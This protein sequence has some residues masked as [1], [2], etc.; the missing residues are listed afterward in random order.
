M[1][2]PQ[3]SLLCLLIFTLALI[4]QG[5]FGVGI[6]ASLSTRE[7]SEGDT[8][9]LTITIT[10]NATSKPTIPQINGLTFDFAG[11]S[12]QFEMVNLQ[13]S[14]TYTYIYDVTG[15]KAGHYTINHI[16]IQADGKTLQAPPL[17]LTVLAAASNPAPDATNAGN[18]DESSGT[19]PSESLD[20]KEKKQTA[21][22]RLI[23]SKKVAYVGEL[24]P[25]QIRVYFHRVNQVRLT[26]L[27]TLDGTA[28]TLSKMDS[29]PAQQTMTIDGEPYTVLTWT[30]AISA[31]KDGTYNLGSN[32]QVT[33]LQQTRGMA[34]S[35]FFGDD[36]FDRF[37]GR[38][39]PK[40]LNLTSK[41]TTM[42][43]L[44]LPDENR[45]KSFTGPV[46]NFTFQVWPVRS[47]NI[48]EG[49]PINLKLVVSGAGNFDDVQSPQMTDDTGWTTY[50]PSEKFYPDNTP[51]T[52]GKKEFQ[53]AMIPQNSSIT[54]IPPFEF[55]YFDPTAARY[56]IKRTPPIPIKIIPAQHTATS[57]DT[58]SSDDQQ[59]NSS[60]P[61]NDFAPNRIE[62]ENF[63]K[64]LVPLWENPWFEA[65]WL[66]PLALLLTGGA[67][68]LRSCQIGSIHSRLRKKQANQAL[69]AT[70][71][72]MD[73]A[74]LQ[75]DS[76]KFLTSCRQVCQQHLAMQWGLPPHA[77]TSADV[78]EKMGETGTGF[79]RIF[80]LID[81]FDYSG[82]PITE[83]QMQE[84][85]ELVR[86][87]LQGVEVP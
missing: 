16:E 46:G 86:Q 63:T 84:L 67:L 85:Q 24:I 20:D 31:F 65:T 25:V 81:A 18:D 10:G 80:E 87:E 1:K 36:I 5:A 58:S 19:T 32:F 51:G 47:K 75:H 2:F 55:S 77:I 17:L 44:P 70:L 82:Q 53:Q 74:A 83:S 11:Q 29:Q 9:R 30:T 64:S 52:S 43:I 72:A 79:A 23:P 48:M 35:G 4:S 68:I 60:T 57:S 59:T 27:P 7:I 3:K 76:R 13:T 71:A 37:F 33:V 12:S 8:A 69:N 26:S 34:P 54:N 38:V 28:F 22:L 61:A 45:P 6:T 14:Y 66:I 39:E 49:D 62:R 40:D 73:E 50:K 41:N 21:F 78:A 15:N 42:T 56:V